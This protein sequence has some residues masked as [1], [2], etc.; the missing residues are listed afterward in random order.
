MPFLIKT[1]NKILNTNFW[2]LVLVTQVPIV[3]NWVTYLVSSDYYRLS[4]ISTF[5]FQVIWFYFFFVLLIIKYFKVL[6]FIR[7]LLLFLTI[8]LQAINLFGAYMHNLE[9]ISKCA[10]FAILRSIES[11]GR[12]GD[13][14]KIFYKTANLVLDKQ[15][16]ID[17]DGN[18][19][20]P[21]YNS[22]SEIA[23]FN[24]CKN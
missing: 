23:K 2:W 3:L 1:W 9:N 13:K 10:D 6:T 16:I 7:I 22:T 14:I 8:S 11:G 18:I 4:I 21:P 15:M 5:W 17:S 19:V 20:G 24:E 12:E